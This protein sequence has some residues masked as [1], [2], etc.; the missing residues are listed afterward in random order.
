MEI[1]YFDL[2]AL[3]ALGVLGVLLFL[4]LFEP[5]LAYQIGFEL[6]APDSENFSPLLAAVID[7]PLLEIR[8]CEVLRNGAVSQAARQVRRN[9]PDFTDR[10][11]DTLSGAADEPP[12][13][14]H[15]GDW[16]PPPIGDVI[17]P[18]FASFW[19]PPLIERNNEKQKLLPIERDF[20]VRHPG[21]RVRHRAGYANEGKCLV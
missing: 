1:N 15:R 12:Q 3:L 13:A 19:L 4:V 11:R 21:T 5:G 17:P 9:T 18:N 6:P 7:E 14:T 2:A 16:Y 10:R 8:D 20:P